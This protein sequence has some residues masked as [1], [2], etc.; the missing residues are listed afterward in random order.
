MYIPDSHSSQVET[1]VFRDEFRLRKGSELTWSEFVIF[2]F[3]DIVYPFY[4]SD[5]IVEAIE[6]IF[7]NEGV[8]FSGEFCTP[9]YPNEVLDDFEGTV[10]Y[11]KALK[12]PTLFF[13]VGGD[14]EPSEAIVSIPEA[15]Y[16]TFIALDIYLN[17]HKEDYNK[18][19][20]YLN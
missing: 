16:Y 11:E 8:G 19:S 5:G 7:S 20:H 4:G 6:K 3:F 13:S 14:I 15:H 12:I 10:G 1:Q 2:Y 18:F 17:I 9:L